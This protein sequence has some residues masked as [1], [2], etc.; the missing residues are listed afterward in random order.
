MRSVIVL[1]LAE[2]LDC[3]GGIKVFLRR[4]NHMSR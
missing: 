3:E 1:K 4:F 2:G